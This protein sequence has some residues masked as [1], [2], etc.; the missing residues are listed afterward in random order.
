M[1]GFFFILQCRQ[2][3]A[4]CD[5]ILNCSPETLLT[6]T[7]QLESIDLVPVSPGD[8]LVKPLLHAINLNYHYYNFQYQM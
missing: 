1:W 7:A 5:E 2:V 4:L 6:H 8:Q 3:V